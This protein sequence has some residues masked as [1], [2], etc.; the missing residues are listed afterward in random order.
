MR[1]NRTRS[2]S[3]CESL[4]HEPGIRT[5]KFQSR[6]LAA[7]TT[8]N[9]SVCTLT[10]EWRVKACPLTPLCQ[11]S[12]Q[13]IAIEVADRLWLSILESICRHVVTTVPEQPGMPL[14]VSATATK[15]IVSSPRDTPSFVL[16]QG[17]H[18]QQHQQHQQQQ[19]QRHWFV[20]GEVV[21]S[22]SSSL[23]YF[24]MSF[25]LQTNYLSI[26]VS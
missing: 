20:S 6:G 24:V 23:F 3:Y 5:W 25:I 22:L 16:C 4:K 1:L 11:L 12:L 19:Q 15:K 14:V 21:I 8:L 9:K 10:S 17:Q 2:L 18:Q 7:S 26:I 13:S